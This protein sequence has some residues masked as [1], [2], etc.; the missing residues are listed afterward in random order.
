MTFHGT[1]V[2]RCD[3]GYEDARCGPIFNERVPDRH[4]D[5]ILFA[6][7]IADV[8]AGVRLARERGLR[9]G[10]RSGGHSWGAWGLRDGAL[11]VDLSRLTEL[12]LAEDGE[13]AIVGPG[14]RGGL[15]LAPFLR[16]RG[17]AF[18]GGHCP[19][20]GVSGYILQ[21]GQGWNGRKWGWACESVVAMD[22]VTADGELVHASENENSDLLWA[23]RGAGPGYF[24]VVV[25]WYLRTYPAPRFPAQANYVFP[26]ERLDEVL[27]WA[28]D[29]LA[30]AGPELEPVVAAAWGG[31]L[32]W[33]GPGEA[34]DG[35]VL[36]MHATALVDSQEEAVAAFAPL[37]RGA[38]LEHALHRESAVPTDMDEEYAVQAVMNPEGHRYA[39]DC[40][41]TNATAEELAPRL[42]P[43]FEGLPTEKAFAI[44]YGWNPPATRPD[45][46]FS[47]EAN[48][49]VAAYVVWEDAADDER[50]AS[51]LTG[52]MRGLEPVGAGAYTGDSDFARRPERFLS[53]AAFER[54]EEIRSARDPER[55]FVGYLAPP[56]GTPNVR[57]G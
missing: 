23:A 3:D 5:A 53:D 10:V 43:L 39:A 22:V 37:A 44:W 15:Q 41:W 9:V 19:R 54:L 57:S 11:L 14:V 1:I 55:L 25:R 31:A 45:M 49:Y 26:M 12:S 36:V 40:I 27:R 17:R 52:A 46:A 38:V 13:T 16:Q 28:H 35:H 30:R 32:P 51:W 8:Q 20:V 7:S 50:W 18:P 34:P 56:G 6:E 48:V 42:R 29:A 33:F 47:V 24:A 21:G 4:P 2:W